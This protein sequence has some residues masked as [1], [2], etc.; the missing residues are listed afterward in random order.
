MKVLQ[1][2][3]L[4]M[5]CLKLGKSDTDPALKFPGRVLLLEM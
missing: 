4:T 2:Y 3:Q 1:R 5:L